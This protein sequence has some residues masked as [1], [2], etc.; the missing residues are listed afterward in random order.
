MDFEH[1]TIIVGVTKNGSPVT[2]PLSRA[3]KSALLAYPGWRQPAVLTD[4]SGYEGLIFTQRNSLRLNVL[5][6]IHEV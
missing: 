1:D 4:F 2:V 5:T 6:K 3:A